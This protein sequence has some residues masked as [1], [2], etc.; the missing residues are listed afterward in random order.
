MGVNVAIYYSAMVYWIYKLVP[1][2][3]VCW[4]CNP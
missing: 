1:S 4:I 3:Y 2:S